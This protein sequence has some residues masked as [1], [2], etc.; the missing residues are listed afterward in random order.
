MNININSNVDIRSYLISKGIPFRESSG[1]IITTCIFNDCDNDSRG[2]EAHL[3]FNIKTGQYYCHKC[4]TQG[5]LT[6]LKKHFGDNSPEYDPQ[7]LLP[8]PLVE[9]ISTPA[10]IITEDKIKE[11]HL[12]LPVEHKDWLINERGLTLEII[13]KAQIG[14][15]EFYGKYWLV[16]PILDYKTKQ[17]FLKLRKL[18][19]DASEGSRYIIYPKGVHHI[20]Y[21]EEKLLSGNYDEVFI[22]EGE[23]DGLVLESHGL[24][25]VSST[26]GA[27]TWHEEWCDSFKNVKRIHI[28]YDNDRYGEE[29]VA[30]VLESLAKKNPHT[31]IFQIKIPK[32]EGVKDVTDFFNDKKYKPELERIDAFLKLAEPYKACI[33]TVKK[34]NDIILPKTSIPP[35]TFIEDIINYTNGVTDTPDEFLATA[36]L[37][38]CS[39]ILEKN[40]Y[41]QLGFQKIRPHLSA[42]LLGRSSILRKSTSINLAKNFLYKITPT[43][44]FSDESTPEA[45]LERLS[46]NPHILLHFGEIGG[47]LKS[48]EKSYMSGFKQLLTDL[49]DCPV[50]YKRTRKDKKGAPI[51]FIVCEPTINIFGAST[52]DWFVEAGQDSDLRSGF[53]ARFLF[54]FKSVRSKEKIVFPK[55]PDE[56]L[57]NNLNNQLKILREEWRGEK[58]LSIEAKEKYANWSNQIDK[59]LQDEEMDKL[60]SFYMRLEVMVIKIAMIIEG[61]FQVK[62][63]KTDNVFQ[64]TNEISGIAMDY[65]ILFGEFYKENIK[66]LILGEFIFTL[67]AKQKKKVVDLLKTAGGTLTQ[68]EILQKG[69]FLSAQLQGILKTLEE[70]EIIMTKDDSQSSGQTK[71]I[72]SLITK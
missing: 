15:G 40:V 48:C 66:T 57:E 18:P 44:I 34:I 38:M 3:Y 12:S 43:L 24:N 65:A 9:K 16:I 41:L 45:F 51:D 8:P 69:G 55:K 33:D 37:I 68:R 52:L 22:T 6:T 1:E 25:A 20:L 36:G 42:I 71:K 2:N 30:K 59:D 60:S 47:F 27:K 5:N 28:S 4:N 29:G 53:L 13:N 10:E 67:T 46:I 23:F 21:G 26:G 31:E 56:E 39:T 11:L 63:F 14:Y 54:C 17:F 62:K 50:E 7:K 72:V 70:E 49:Y 64:N 61:L 32:I 19:D 35:G 58:F